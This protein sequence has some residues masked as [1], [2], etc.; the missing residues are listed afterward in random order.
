MARVIACREYTDEAHQCAMETLVLGLAC[1]H[2]ALQ[3]CRV[4]DVAWINLCAGMQKLPCRYGAPAFQRHV[5]SFTRMHATAAGMPEVCT[6]RSQY[7]LFECT[8]D[9]IVHCF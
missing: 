4:K 1:R 9:M 7:N 3:P 5:V 8:T 6:C 2:A